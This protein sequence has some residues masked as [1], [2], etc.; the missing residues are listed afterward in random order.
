MV[1]TSTKIRCFFFKKKLVTFGTDES[2]VRLCMYL[3]NCREYLDLNKKKKIKPSTSS[4]KEYEFMKACSCK[5]CSCKDMM[6]AVLTIYSFG[7]FGDK[8]KIKMTTYHYKKYLISSG[9]WDSIWLSMI[10]SS[11]SRGYVWLSSFNACMHVLP[12]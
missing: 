6:I 5:A 2:L 10:T 11:I 9:F 3:S 8:K 7:L 12:S 1:V 4:K